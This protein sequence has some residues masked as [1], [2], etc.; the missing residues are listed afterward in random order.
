MRI[1]NE[2]LG[3]KELKHLLTSEGTWSIVNVFKYPLYK[4]S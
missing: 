4:L 3:V 2:I 1:T